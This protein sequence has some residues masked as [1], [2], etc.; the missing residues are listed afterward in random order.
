PE[1]AHPYQ[2]LAPHVDM[3]IASP[4][5]TSTVDPISVE[6]FKDDAYCQEFYRTKEDLWKSTEKL[7]S[8]IGRA[9]DFDVIFVVGGF[10]PMY[11]LATD[12]TTIALVREFHDADRVIVALCHG[13]AALVH[14]E[15]AD[16]TPLLGGKRVTG[17]SD[18]EEDQAYANKIAPPNMP[19]HLE[20]ALNKASGGNYEKADQA[21]GSHVISSPKL[22]L[23]QNPASAHDLGVALL[24]V[25]TKK[26]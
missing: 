9:K 24:E 10:G 13:V 4:L 22:L 2:V 7:A 19:F 25:L 14:V 16:G 15:L 17:F 26:K 3:T 11:D 23:G 18:E 21:W 5:G 8:F 12:K 6:R 20:Q 1:F